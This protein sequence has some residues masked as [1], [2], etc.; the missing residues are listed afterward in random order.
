MIPLLYILLLAISIILSGV[1]LIQD[2][3]SGGLSGAFGGV[4]GDAVL[5]QGSAGGISKFTAWI[6]IAFFAVC[7]LIGVLQQGDDDS[8]GA[9]D[10]PTRPGGAV[11]STDGGQPPVVPGGTPNNAGT[12][13][14][15]PNNSG[16]PSGNTPNAN[17]P[18][19][20]TPNSNTPNNA[21]SGD[22]PPNPNPPT[23][24]TSNSGG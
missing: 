14:G 5:G 21:G 4:G 6:S 20:N 1:I 23:P 24:N 2:S 9:V 17:T 22:T 18:N 13:N 11:I 16:T 8:S 12:P 15:T 10:D 7:I 3:K 19:G